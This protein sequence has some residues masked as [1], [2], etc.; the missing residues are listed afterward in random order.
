MPTDRPT[1]AAKGSLL[2][3]DDEPTIAKDMGLVLARAGYEVLTA[4]S[5]HEGWDLFQRQAPQVCA[6]VTDLAMPGDWNGLELVRRVRQ[7]SPHTPV[8][9]VTGYKPSEALGPCSGLL[10]KP[11]T[12]DLLRAGVR[13]VIGQ[14]L[15]GD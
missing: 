2:L 15:R 7:A 4:F 11:F 6:V 14:A 13:Q 10:P 9:L 5:A 12:A 8:L 3:L 1:L